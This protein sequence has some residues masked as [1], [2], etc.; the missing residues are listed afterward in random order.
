MRLLSEKT[1]NK[2]KKKFS[3]LGAIRFF[4]YAIK[5]SLLRILND[6]FLKYLVVVPICLLIRLIRPIIFIRIGNLNA[7]KIGPLSSLPELYLCEKDKGIQPQNTFDIFYDT[8]GN[9]VD[10]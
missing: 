5:Y 6:F 10:L 9:L 4:F 7:S 2:I 1:F 3:D 8:W